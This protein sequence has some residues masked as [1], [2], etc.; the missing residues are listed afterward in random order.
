MRIA[1]RSAPTDTLH[2]ADRP[3]LNRFTA[4]G[5]LAPPSRFSGALGGN[6]E[7]DPRKEQLR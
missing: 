6:K 7:V 3:V 2:F 1:I 5:G 4:G